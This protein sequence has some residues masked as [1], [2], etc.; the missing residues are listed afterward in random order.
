M[1]T[2]QLQKRSVECRWGAGTRWCAGHD[3]ILMNKGNL[4]TCVRHQG[5]SIIDL[6]WCNAEVAPRIAKWKVLDKESYSNHR[7]VL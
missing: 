2:N 3:L 5:S 4:A 7:C 6:T 1:Q